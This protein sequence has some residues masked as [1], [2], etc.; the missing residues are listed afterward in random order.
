MLS[1]VYR[2]VVRPTRDCWPCLSVSARRIGLGSDV[3]LD[4]LPA[5][6]LKARRVGCGIVY[7]SRAVAIPAASTVM[8]ENSILDIVRFANIKN[9]PVLCQLAPYHVNSGTGFQVVRIGPSPLELISPSF[10]SHLVLL[11]GT[12][13]NELFSGSG[14]FAVRWKRWL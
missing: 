11:F 5:R 6:L 4:L 14:S 9:V 10:K 7:G 8:T 13:A 2:V 12:V 1:D 3:V